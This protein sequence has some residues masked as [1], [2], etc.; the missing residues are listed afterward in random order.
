MSEEKRE[1]KK[2]RRKKREKKRKMKK[3]R[4][5]KKE[6]GTKFLNGEDLKEERVDI[7]T[8]RF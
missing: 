4:I 1:K 6:R 3:E 5:K 8:R 7:Y 2:G